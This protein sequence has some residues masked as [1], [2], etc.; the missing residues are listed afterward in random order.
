MA[1]GVKKKQKSLLKWIIVG[2][3]VLAA[4]IIVYKIFTG[5]VINSNVVT[6]NCNQVS[7]TANVLEGCTT[8]INGLNVSVLS[9]SVAGNVVNASLRVV[10]TTF[11]LTT[12]ISSASN[13]SGQKTF[14]LGTLNYSVT[15]IGATNTMATIQVTTCVPTST[16]ITP[17]C[18]PKT[19]SQFGKQ[20]GVAN[21]GCG[22]ILNC[23]NCA[24]GQTCTNGQ[25]TSCLA[26]GKTLTP[27][28][29]CCSGGFH[30][31]LWM[32]VCN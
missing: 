5:Q 13:P 27:S 6:P 24:S 29:R 26:R 30:R 21:D 23:G 2:L 19:C 18:I 10:G 12:D 15:L 28:G 3:L 25:C 31:F 11:T 17:Q 32:N 7:N 9:S 20:C 16:P 1:K 4:L 22:K 14:Y 8:N